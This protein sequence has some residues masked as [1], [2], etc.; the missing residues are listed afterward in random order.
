MLA[1]FCSKCG[2]PTKEGDR[3]CRQCGAAIKVIADPVNQAAQAPQMQQPSPAN[4]NPEGTVMLGD[5]NSAAAETQRVLT[6]NIILSLDEMLR[7]G[8]KVVDF[9]NGKRY[10]ITL[11]PGIEPGTTIVIE[12]TGIADRSTGNLCKIELNAVVE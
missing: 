9:G 10:S 11:P 7:G 2:N 1:K 4:Y 3:F 5:L 8:N 12:N 6:A